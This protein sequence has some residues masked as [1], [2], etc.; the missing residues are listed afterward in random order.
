MLK[1]PSRASRSRP[2]ARRLLQGLRVASIERHGKAL[3]IVTNEGPCLQ[4]HLGMSGQLL[5]IAEHEAAAARPTHTHAEWCS[6]HG[7]VL[8]FRDPRRFGSLL[9]WPDRG[10]LLAH[11]ARLGADALRVDAAALWTTL[12]STRRGVKAL[13]L[14]QRALAGVGNI[15]ADEALFEAGIHPVR[16]ARSLNRNDAE[17]LATAIQ[18]VLQRGLDACGSTLRDYRLPDGTLG[19]GTSWH[20]VYARERQPCPTCKQPIQAATIAGRTSHFCAKCQ[21][22]ELTSCPQPVGWV[23]SAPLR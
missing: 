6:D 19:R 3:G 10:S 17:R 2:E 1:S 23:F 20:R 22:V 8:R 5:L 12:Q 11:W 7:A 15:Y 4:V 16:P 21:K 13:L 14:D 9:W 18:D